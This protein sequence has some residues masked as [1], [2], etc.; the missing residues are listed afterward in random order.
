M[1]NRNLSTNKTERD[2]ILIQRRNDDIILIY[3]L[4]CNVH[5]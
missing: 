2:I 1:H 5:M 4:R 3:Q